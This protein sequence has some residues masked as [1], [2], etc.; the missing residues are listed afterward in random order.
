M[1]GLKRHVFLWGPVIALGLTNF[2]LSSLSKSTLWF[3]AINGNG[4]VLHVAGSVVIGTLALRVCHDGFSTL[5]PR[6]TLMAI[7]GCFL[8]AVSDEIHQLTVP[9]RGSTPVFDVALD[10]VGVLLAVFLWL[11]AQFGL[12]VFRGIAHPKRPPPAKDLTIE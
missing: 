8:W 11:L 7:A 6:P 3:L 2:Y 10:T 5:S 1:D 4:K 9:G 12:G